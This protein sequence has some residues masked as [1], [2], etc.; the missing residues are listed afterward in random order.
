MLNQQTHLRRRGQKLKDQEKGSARKQKTGT[1]NQT[2][3]QKG[4]MKKVIFNEIL[5]RLFFALSRSEAKRGR[6]KKDKTKETQKTK[7]NKKRRQEEN[8]YKKHTQNKRRITREGSKSQEKERETL[9]K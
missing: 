6:H 7:E 8:K 1:R 5:L 9:R 4:W 2:K 3:G